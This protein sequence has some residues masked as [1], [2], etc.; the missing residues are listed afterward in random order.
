M[1]YPSKKVTVLPPGKPAAVMA[2]KLFITS[3]PPAPAG[4]VIG[5]L[6][7]HSL[8]NVHVPVPGVTPVAAN[9][10]PTSLFIAPTN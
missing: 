3:N 9:D 6:N 10:V 1:K 4:V 5:T 2:L 7:V 8:A